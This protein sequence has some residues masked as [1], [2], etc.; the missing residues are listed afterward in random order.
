[1]LIST[2]LA[3]L[4]GANL[5]GADLSEA[6]LSGAYL[7][8]FQMPQEGSLTVWKAVRGGIA[9]LEVPADSKRTACLINRKC[10]AEF[11]RTL[12]IVMGDGSGVTSAAGRHDKSTIYTVGEITIPHSYNDDPRLDCASGIHFFLTKEEAQEWLALME[13]C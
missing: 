12:A 11:V 13:H 8:A 4:S 2:E 3:N 6:N 1:M 7:P 5:G 9:K 10:R